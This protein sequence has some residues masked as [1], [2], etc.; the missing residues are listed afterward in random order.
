MQLV[1]IQASCGVKSSA[2]ACSVAGAKGSMYSS[3]LFSMSMTTSVQ[4]LPSLWKGPIRVENS[5][6]LLYA[7]CKNILCIRDFLL[8]AT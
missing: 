7:A 5:P 2:V 3:S 6:N 4:W 1:P 8:V